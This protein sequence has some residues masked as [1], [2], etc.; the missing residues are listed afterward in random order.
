MIA[1]VMPVLAGTVAMSVAATMVIYGRA[2]TGVIRDIGIFFWILR[3]PFLLSQRL[4]KDL[5]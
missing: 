2:T 5:R 1:A 3:L 4:R